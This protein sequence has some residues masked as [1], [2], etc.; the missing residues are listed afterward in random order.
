MRFKEEIVSEKIL[1]T[2]RKIIA[3][4][5]S[6]KYGHEQREIATELGITQP[7]VSQ[8]ITDSRG[9]KEIEEKFRDDPQIEILLEDATSK[10]AKNQ[11]IEKEI[12]EII[13][14]IKSKNM[15]EEFTKAEKIL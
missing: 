3:K 6:K 4:N 12:S 10:A 8:Y 14:Y 13:E 9:R 11:D 5:L 1:P 15:I 2:I 7:T